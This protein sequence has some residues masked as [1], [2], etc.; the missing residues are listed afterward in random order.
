MPT[1]VVSNK[2]KFFAGAKTT[3]ERDEERR[4]AD[5]ARKREHE[6][7]RT[8][9]MGEARKVVSEVMASA[10]AALRGR[11][12]LSRDTVGSRTLRV[13]TTG[14]EFRCD[15]FTTDGELNV[16]ADGTRGGTDRVVYNPTSD[17]LALAS[18]GGRNLLASEHA[19]ATSGQSVDLEDL[20]YG[21]LHQ[22]R[23]DH[24]L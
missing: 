10:E 3:E 17:K 4:Q 9:L 12:E 15:F 16:K 5:E 11:V 22:W 2:D 18:G 23:E 8:E 13:P 14:A 7:R 6:I 24:K 21:L 19:K 20:L 1:R